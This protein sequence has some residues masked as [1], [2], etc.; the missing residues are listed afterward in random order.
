MPISVTI[1]DYKEGWHDIIDAAG[2]LTRRIL[3]HSNVTTTCT[4]G[5]QCNVTRSLSDPINGACQ[6]FISSAGIHP[7][8]YV[9]QY[10]IA[11]NVMA[12]RASDHVFFFELFEKVYVGC[13]CVLTKVHPRAWLD[14]YRLIE[15]RCLYMHIRFSKS[16]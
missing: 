6:H 5:G 3:C 7:R 14:F 2:N 15:A 8:L 16:G 1:F 11:E 13:M 10:C 12:L 4:W 9:C